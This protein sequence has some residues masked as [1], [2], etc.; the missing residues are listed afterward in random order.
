MINFLRDF[1]KLLNDYKIRAY[2]HDGVERF[3]I[4]LSWIFTIVLLCLLSA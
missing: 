4:S 2:D 3:A 1:W